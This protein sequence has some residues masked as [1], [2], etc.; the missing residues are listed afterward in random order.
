MNVEELKAE[1]AKL[2]PE[3][4]FALAEWIEQSEGIRDLRRTMEAM[5][6]MGKVNIAEVERAADGT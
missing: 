1:A 2:L 5:M 3:D 6:K 4:R